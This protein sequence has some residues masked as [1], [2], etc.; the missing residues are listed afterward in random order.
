M[1]RAAGVRGAAAAA[2]LDRVPDPGQRGRG[3]GR[4]TGDL[5]RFEAAPRTP[6]RPRRS[7]RR[8]DPDRDRRLAAG[9]RSAGG[10]VGPWFP[11]PLRPIPTRTRSTG[12]AGRLAVDG[13]AAPARAAESARALGLRV[14]GGVRLR[15]PRGRLGRRRSEA[16]SRQLALR[17]RRHMHAGRPRFEAD[18][19]EREEPPRAS[20]M[21]SGKATSTGCGICSPPTSIWSATA[22]ARPRG[23]PRASPARR[24]WPGCSPRASCRLPRSGRRRTARGQ[25]PAGRALPRPGRQSAQHLALDT[26]DGQI[27]TIRAVLNPDKPATWARSRTP[28]RSPARRT[29]PAEADAPPHV[30][31]SCI[32]VQRRPAHHP[33]MA[34]P[35]PTSC[36]PAATAASRT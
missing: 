11:E 33:F 26:L 6:R 35:C 15:L 20:S 17:A 24:T 22:V 13:G 32:R 34:F 10:V 9:P 4:G 25:R 1:T 27:Q 23:G 14:A 18:R 19:R 5:A 28:G 30:P 12:G 21:P 2:V 29:R 36:D 31:R 7:F 16:A 8:G 3:G